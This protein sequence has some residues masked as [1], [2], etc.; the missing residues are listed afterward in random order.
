MLINARH[1]QCIDRTLGN[2]QNVPD[3]SSSDVEPSSNDPKFNDL[4]RIGSGH[5][6]QEMQVEPSDVVELGKSSRKHIIGMQDVMEIL[7]RKKKNQHGD[8]AETSSC[9]NAKPSKRLL[10]HLEILKEMKE[11]N[12]SCATS[13]A[14]KMEEFS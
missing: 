5:D 4:D 1:D 3:V 14:G 2:L 10:K 12:E 9:G 6:A 8:E 13:S 7:A 11:A